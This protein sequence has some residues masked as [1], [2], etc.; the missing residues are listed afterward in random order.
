LELYDL[1]SST[2]IWVIKP[3]R[4]TWAG[5]VAHMGDRRGAYRVLEGRTEGTR[6]LGRPRERT[7]G[8]IKMQLL[9][10]EWGGLDWFNLA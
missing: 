8:N 2:N 9:E 6:P 4:I 10:M 5:H 7:K 3:G 1:Y